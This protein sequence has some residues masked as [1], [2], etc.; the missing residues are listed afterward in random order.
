MHEESQ[1]TVFIVDDHPS[2]ILGFSA[3][4]EASGRYK[5]LGSAKSA[6]EARQALRGLQAES[7][8]PDLFVMDLSLGGQNGLELIRDLRKEDKT[9][10][11]TILSIACRPDVILDALEAGVLG[12]ISKEQDGAAA[13]RVLDAVYEG[14]YGMEGIVL[15]AVI[16][17][18]LLLRTMK[19]GSERSQYDGLTPREKEVF[20]LTAMNSATDSIAAELGISHKSVENIRSAIF[21]K[22]NFHDRLEL[23]RY[24]LRLG[25]ID[26]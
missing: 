14:N 19:A 22:L 9:R 15:N 13:I 16:E 23:Y 26:D 25:I 20:R 5:V 10:R 1:R 17:N 6:A 4:I 8:V 18:A 11:F 12:F 7:L 21:T 24:A 3:M 2:I